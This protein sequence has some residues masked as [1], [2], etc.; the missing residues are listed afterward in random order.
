[1]S[2]T[3]SQFF[4][5][6]SVK[7]KQTIEVR[8]GTMELLLESLVDV[9]MRA[10]LN[11]MRVAARSIVLRY[12]NLIRDW[13]ALRATVSGEFRRQLLSQ[14]KLNAKKQTSD[15]ETKSNR[16]RTYLLT[17]L[18]EKLRTELPGGN[19]KRFILCLS[20]YLKRREL[21]VLKPLTA[22]R[23]LSLCTLFENTVRECMLDKESQG[24]STSPGGVITIEDEL[25]AICPLGDGT[26]DLSIH[27]TDPYFI[28]KELHERKLIKSAFIPSVNDRA[29]IESG[30]SLAR[31]AVAKMLQSQQILRA[32]LVKI[33]HEIDESLELPSCVNKTTERLVINLCKE[34]D[35]ALNLKIMTRLQRAITEP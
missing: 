30:R 33:V 12:L 34:Q 21:A 17:G 11:T 2:K 1:M 19:S 7:T 14:S 28:L 6:I 32:N 4:L 35:L 16:H 22:Q 5:C 31:S 3:A 29:R 8:R 24:R 23:L 26:Q 9:I 27:Q 15:R 18:V 20:A 10:C 13:K 25:K